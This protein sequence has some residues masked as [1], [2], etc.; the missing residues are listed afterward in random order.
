MIVEDHEL[1]RNFMNEFITR[2]VR[3]ARIL[4]VRAAYRA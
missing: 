2:P 1:N 4:E 3:F